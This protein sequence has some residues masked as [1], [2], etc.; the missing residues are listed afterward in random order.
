MY[1]NI[2]AS[3]VIDN[4]TIYIENLSLVP[5]ITVPK[6]AMTYVLQNLFPHVSQSLMENNLLCYWYLSLNLTPNHSEK[7]K[8]RRPE[9][10]I[11]SAY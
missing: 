6:N 4:I 11:Y 1:T 3:R 5:Q 9:I 8:Y 2:A 7:K 10:D